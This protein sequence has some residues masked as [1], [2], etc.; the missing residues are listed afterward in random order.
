MK[1]LQMLKEGTL[2]INIDESW[3]SETNFVRKTWL[4]ANAPGTFP[5]APVSHR[6]ALLV[7]LDSEGRIYYSLTQA[8]TD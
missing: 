4:P 6:L 1:M 3:I 2:I 5:L 8:A 7:A